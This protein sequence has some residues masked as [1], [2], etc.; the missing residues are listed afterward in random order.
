M[1]KQRYHQA[2]VLL[3]AGVRVR[4]PGLVTGMILA[5]IGAVFVLGK[6]REERTESVR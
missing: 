3:M 5:L 6:I 2:N 1:I 4:Y